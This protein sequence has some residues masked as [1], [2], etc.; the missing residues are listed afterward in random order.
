MVTDDLRRSRLTVFFR[1]LLAIPHYVWF[2]LWAVAAFFA[3]VANWVVTVVRGRPAAP[4][5]RFLTAF[6]RYVAQLSA[7]LYLAANPY[8]AFTGEPGYPVD[9]GLDEPSPQ[10]RLGAFFRL[11]LALPALCLAAALGGGIGGGGGGS[12][13]SRAA[14][15]AET[16]STA[17]SWG[18]ATTAGAFLAWFFILARG[19]APSGIRDLAAY[20]VGY[21]AQAWAYLFLLTG[22]YPNSDPDA[23]LPERRYPEHPV[24]I[25]DAD[26]LRRSR[27]TV[28]F[29]L[30][31]AIPHFVWIT[32]WSIAAILAVI[33]GWF[34][35]LVLGRLPT[36]LH[37]FLA[38][39]IRYAAH[40]SAYLF[41]VANPFPGFVGA[42]GSYPVDLRIAP[43]ERQHRLSVFFRIFLAIPAWILSSGY[44]GALVVAGVLGWFYALATGRMPRGLQRLGCA[45]IRYSEQASAYAFLVTPRYPYASPVLEP[46]AA[47]AAEV[48]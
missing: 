5:A 30:L 20:A 10:G 46:E 23:M 38:A 48:A 19:R 44:S 39:W 47:P 25:V 29:R 26:D 42:E 7:Y 41:V 36:P 37:R 22:R 11:F 32:L 33:V 1:L 28:F 12:A 2:L 45:A 9:V 4:L 43:P 17:A 14:E 40:L 8:P 24:T 13:S 6:V 27:L 3:A 34:A 35:A 16:W 15:D 18:G 21:G 31:L